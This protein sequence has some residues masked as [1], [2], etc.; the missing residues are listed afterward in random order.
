MLMLWLLLLA[1]TFSSSCYSSAAI[2]IVHCIILYSVVL[3][4]GWMDG[5]MDGWMIDCT[6]GGMQYD[7]GEKGEMVFY[8]TII[9]Q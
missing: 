5:W 3:M 4:I 6:G 8:G 1:E 9:N 2:W 7:T